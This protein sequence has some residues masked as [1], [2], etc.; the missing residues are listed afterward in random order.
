M[1]GLREVGPVV[2]SFDAANYTKWVIYMHASLGQGGLSSATSAAPTPP[3]RAL[4]SFRLIKSRK[5]VFAWT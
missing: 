1:D 3:S 4:H 2:F 5:K